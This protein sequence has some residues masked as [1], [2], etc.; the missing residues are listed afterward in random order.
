MVACGDLGIFSVVP[1]FFAFP[2]GMQKMQEQQIVGCAF[3]CKP[4]R[5]DRL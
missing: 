5:N 2:K 4:G 1:A 3:V